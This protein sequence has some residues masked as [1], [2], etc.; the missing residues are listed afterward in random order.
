MF[1]W[2]RSWRRRRLLRTPF[3]DAWE[4]ILQAGVAHYREL[5][6]DEQGRL[7]D[8]VQVFVAEK[9]WE[10]CGG[11]ELSDEIRVTV[12]AGAGLLVLGR[13]HRYFRNVM[14]ILVYPST[15][16]TPDRARASMG[17]AVAPVSHGIP[18]LG[19]AW[20]GGP[21]IV[22]WDAARKQARHPEGGHDVVLHEFAHKLDML[23]GA[24]DGT[25][26]LGSKEA[27]AEWVEVCSREFTQLRQRS[28]AHRPTFLDPYG[29]TNEAE[30]FA[31]ATES[32]F[33]RAEAMQRDAPALYDLLRRFYEQDPAARVARRRS[34]R[35]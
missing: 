24:A 23:D 10:G 14:S 2:F 11:L 8:F 19:E 13:E 30:F 6:P 9:H 18:I 16:K 34:E 20:L 5:D 17:I 31:V 28:E 4:A 27:Y 33:A 35:G 12:A 21:L 1:D 15:V 32:F 29:A 3:P 22:V 25:P 7:R 26:P